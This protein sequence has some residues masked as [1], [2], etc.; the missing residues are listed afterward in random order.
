MAPTK[1]QITPPQLKTVEF[2]LKGTAP[3][4]QARFGAKAQQAMK[5]NMLAG[6]QSRKGKAKPPRDFDADYA[7][8]HHI[9]VEGWRGIP[10]SSFRSAIISACRL[11][12]FKMTLAKL[13]VFIE[14]DGFDAIDGVPLVKIEGE[15]ERLEM[16][17]RN[18]N[19]QPDIRV[20]PMWREWSV[21]LLVTYDEAQFSREDVTNLLSRVGKQVGI[22]EG[23]HDSKKSAG[24][25]W[26]TFAITNQ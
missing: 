10:A 22:G 25:G 4:V 3:Y 16:V 9:S 14:A 13:S 24:M 6:S 7:Q 26:G 19:T 2:H 1:V 20:R 17:T 8:A 23:R 21:R 15:P 5:D 18:A 12:G 11:V